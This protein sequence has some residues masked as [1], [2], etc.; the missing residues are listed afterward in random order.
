MSKAPRRPTPKAATPKPVPPKSTVA[1][2]P[3]KAKSVP[4]SDP[5]E[6]DECYTVEMVRK[7]RWN[8]KKKYFEYLIKWKGYAEA[9]NSWEPEHNLHP[10]LLTAELAKKKYHSQPP[11]EK[12]KAANTTSAHRPARLAKSRRAWEAEERDAMQAILS[13]IRSV[14]AVRRSEAGRVEFAVLSQ[15]GMQRFWI[16]ADELMGLKNGPK[17]IATFLLGHIKLPGVEGR[18]RRAAR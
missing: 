16:D 5:F 10:D 9:D 4:Q 3:A 8:A 11:E 12:G 15:P 18:P 6:G 1:P 7:R 14:L 13:Q 17:L 2:A